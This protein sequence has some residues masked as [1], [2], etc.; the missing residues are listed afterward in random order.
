MINIAP[1]NKYEDPTYYTFIG[2]R[3]GGKNYN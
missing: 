2:K 3:G 1:Q